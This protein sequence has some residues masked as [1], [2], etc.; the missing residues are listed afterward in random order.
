MKKLYFLIT[1]CFTGLLSFGQVII[2]ELADPNNNTGARYVEIYNVGATGFDLTGW[3]L[4]RWTNAGT[5]PQ[6]TGVDLSSIGTLA[7]G[8]F[9]IIAANGTEFASVYGMAADI[10]AG[11]GGPADSNGDDK[12]AI[13]DASDNT[14]DIYGTPGVSSN[15]A[16]SADNFEDGRAERAVGV[17]GPNATWT[18][19]EWNTDNDQGF[20]D[21]AQDAPAG[22]DPGAWIGASN[23]CGVSLGVATYT[24]NTNTLGD[25]NDSVTI[26]IPYLGSNPGI[27]NV[28][29]SSGGVVGGDD[30]SGI[31][32]GTIT[33][34]G[35]S[36]GDSWDITLVGGDCDGT[37]ASGMVSVA[38]CD[39]APSTCFDLSLGIEL[40]E[41]VTVASNSDMDEWTETGGTYDM[42]GF[43][44]GGCMEESNTWLIFGPLDMSVVSD[45]SLIFDATEGFDGSELNV[46]YTSDYS[47]LCPDSATWTSVQTIAT[48]GSYSVD[49]SGASG[50]DVFIGIQ[51][52]DSD[53]SFSSWSL[54][55]VSIG[56]FGACPTLGSRPT[57]DCAI[58]DVTLGEATYTCATNT[59]GDNNDAVTVNIP[60]TG[61]D[62]TII[63]ITAPGATVGGDDPALTTD[64][65]ITLTGLSEGDGWS[66]T[67][68][69]GDCD[70]TMLSGTIAATQ[71]DPVTM[72]LVINEILADPAG[73]I[74]GDANGDGTRDGSDDEFVELYNIGASSLD[75]SDY[76][77]EDGFGT[78]HTFPPGTILPSNS[79]ITVF[80][81]GTPTGI[82]GLVQVATGGQLGL[83]NSGDDVIV[84]NGAGVIVVSYT[85]TGATDQS[86]A[87]SPDYTGAFV[88]H[89]T[90]TGNGGA[91]F[92]PNNEN[93]TVLST[94]DFSNVSFSIYPNPT[95]TG[96][97][98]ITSTIIDAMTVQVFDVLGKQ[99][100]IQRVTNNNLDVS[101]LRSGLYIVKITQNNASVTKK[102][103]IK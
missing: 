13:F 39:P 48:T 35:L 52:L 46:Q 68:N 59:A 27:T 71:C 99:V 26:N 90:I 49:I 97:V 70:G 8:A 1:L 88:A 7:P 3:E 54:S 84:K 50:T 16:S 56:A 30:P 82:S 44:G 95:N 9:A 81:G 74:T 43:C 15:N 28:T 2:T 69:G 23:A 103:V 91:L 42:N 83:N 51:Y 47:S 102:L 5:V 61:V 79:F 45:L 72:D 37:M 100:I 93:D 32:D 20:G 85:Y 87:R 67:L 24:C 22:F 17:S 63:S 78:R 73:D 89:S 41:L 31:A 60:Y 58:C 62:N 21:G 98:T 80:G 64:G 11:T 55:N 57:S 6:T 36:E 65:T 96:N 14:I 4:R 92:S 101:N 12:I 86:V 94:N 38:E 18:A 76:T 33:I 40:F 29:T 75:I 53:G 25:N 19:S 34:T 77:I 66:I 10:S